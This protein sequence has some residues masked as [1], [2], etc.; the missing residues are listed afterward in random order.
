MAQFPGL[1]VS[2]WN[3]FFADVNVAGV[4]KAMGIN[5]FASYY[6][7]DVSRTIAFGD[8][9]NDISMIRA[10]GMGIAMGGASEAVKSVAD[11]ITE[12]VDEHGIRNALVRFGI[13]E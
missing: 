9:G 13:L 8:G 6:G 2:R 7:F 1:S 10:A 5:E 4:N 3:P 11:Y 12:T